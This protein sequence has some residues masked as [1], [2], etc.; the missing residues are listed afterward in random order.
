[1]R[2]RC[3]H[4]GKPIDI[5]YPLTE[6][7]SGVVTVIIWSSGD[8]EA[9]L[10]WLFIMTMTL[11]SLFDMEAMEFP[12]GLLFFLALV[13]IM[14]SFTDGVSFLS[15]I[16]GSM[17]LSLP[18]L[19]VNRLREVIGDGDIFI[20]MITG[21]TFGCEFLFR[22]VLVSCITGLLFSL[23]TGKKK[24]PFCPF[25]TIGIMASLL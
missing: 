10:Y 2:G 9:F 13:G 16:L 21:W 12:T 17:V 14:I 24:I 23:I 3:R 1:M 19:S 15:R 5:K 6:V 11:I 18:M 20:F 22:S 25:L 7:F 4:C 8:S